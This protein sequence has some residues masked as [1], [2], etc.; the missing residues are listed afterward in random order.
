MGT[1]LSHYGLSNDDARR[2]G[3]ALRASLHGFVTLEAADA[4]GR[5]DRNA[6]FEALVE[7]FLDALNRSSR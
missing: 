6:S 4:L 5:S 3:R 1:V 7:L 2:T